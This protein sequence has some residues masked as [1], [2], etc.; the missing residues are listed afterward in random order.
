LTQISPCEW[1]LDEVVITIRGAKHWLWRAVD[2]DGFRS[3]RSGSEPKRPD[4][5]AS[6]WSAAWLPYSAAIHKISVAT[7]ANADTMMTPADAATAPATKDFDIS[8]APNHEFHV[9]H[10]TIF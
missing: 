7:L 5:G 3:R 4:S 10:H 6:G 1:H 9:V 2:Q 8:I